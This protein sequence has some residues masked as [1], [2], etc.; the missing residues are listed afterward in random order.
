MTEVTVLHKPAYKKKEHSKKIVK[1]IYSTS[2]LKK[3]SFARLLR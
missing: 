2:R 1:K 3:G